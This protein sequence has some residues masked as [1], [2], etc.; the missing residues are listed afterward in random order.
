MGKSNEQLE[1]QELYFQY[2]PKIST[3]LFLHH[4]NEKS[5]F[6]KSRCHLHPP[7]QMKKDDLPRCQLSLVD[8]WAVAQFDGLHSGDFAKA[9]AMWSMQM[10]PNFSTW[11][12]MWNGNPMLVSPLKLSVCQLSCYLLH[13]RAHGMI[14]P[15]DLTLPVI[16]ES[17]IILTCSLVPWKSTVYLYFAFWT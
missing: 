8:H 3:I 9:T 16:K 13:L 7:H 2:L 10:K 12:W 1:F 17:K 14:S 11:T 5:I 6:I 15:T 4:L